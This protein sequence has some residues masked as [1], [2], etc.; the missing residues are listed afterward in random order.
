MSKS[1]YYMYDWDEFGLEQF[2]SSD[3]ADRHILIDWC[4]QEI[5]YCD[6]HAVGD[7]GNNL[8]STV[9]EFKSLIDAMAF[10]L[11]WAG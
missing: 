1:E 9:Y 2:V 11:R 8:I 10:K 6:W 4:K 3:H 7:H 5:G